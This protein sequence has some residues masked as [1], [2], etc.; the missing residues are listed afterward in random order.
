MEQDISVRLMMIEIKQEIDLIEEHE[1]LIKK[2][3]HYMFGVGFDAGRRDVYMRY[4]KKKTPIIQ[5]DENHNR[6]AQYESVAAASRASTV[7]T[8]T[9]FEAMQKHWLTKAGYYWEKVVF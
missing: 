7:A 1:Q 4:S 2:Y 6:I 5:R 8:S 9:I 3:L